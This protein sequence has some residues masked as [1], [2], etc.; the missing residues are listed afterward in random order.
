VSCTGIL[1][2][3]NPWPSS[4][5]SPDLFEGEV[6]HTAR[7][8]DDVDLNGKD[9][10]VIGAGASAAQVVPSLLNEPYHIKSL[11]Q[12][13]RAAP[14]VMPRLEEPFGKAKY[15]KY[16]PTVLHYLPLL[17]WLYRIG[18]HIIVELVW[19][20]LLQKKHANWRK[21][22]ENSTRERTYALIPTK[23]HRL[24]T[25]DYPY[26]CKRRI[27]DT[28]WLP[29]MCAP[30]YTLTNHA[31]IAIDKKQIT[32]SGPSHQTT[33]TSTEPTTETFPADIIVLAT[34][35]QGTRWL[36]PLSVFGRKNLPLH[37]LWHQ[38]GGP[39]AYLGLSI[40]QFPNFFL[41]VGPNTANGT[42]SLILTIE[43]TT[44]YIATLIKPI[45]RGQ[46]ETVEIRREAMGRWMEGV[47][48]G[49]GRTVFGECES[50][51]RDAGGKGWNSVLYS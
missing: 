44:S 23:Y 25:P 47:K 49:L 6:I 2:E 11:T 10:V 43:N 51:Y 27:F 39:Q 29:S 8:R 20:M 24:M 5:P 12:I 40:D 37:D 1:V 38:R 18:I 34:G 33:S 32:L 15:A 36:H 22:M 35:F 17:G 42:A 3:P 45:V 9:I 16:A 7:W 4:L 50:W 21:G 31:I 28:N 46:V 19:F 14:W 41:A 13:M 30:N 26:G 48:R